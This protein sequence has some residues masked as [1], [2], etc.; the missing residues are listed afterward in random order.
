MMAT[1]ESVGVEESAMALPQSR[2]LDV[3]ADGGPA[4]FLDG[5]E[6]Q[7][8]G[9]AGDGGM[10]FT[11]VVHESGIASDDAIG[12]TQSGPF[13]QGEG[14]RNAAGDDVG[15]RVVMGDEDDRTTDEAGERRPGETMDRDR[16]DIGAS[17][18]ADG[19]DVTQQAGG[20][21][22]A[23]TAR[24]RHEDGMA[25]GHL[26][27]HR[28]AERQ[29][30]ATV[31]TDDDQFEIAR[32]RSDD[33]A[34]PCLDGADRIEAWIDGVDEAEPMEGHRGTS[35][36]LTADALERSSTGRRR[37]SPGTGTAARWVTP[38]VR[39]SR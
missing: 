18:F 21:G 39:R 33:G 31:A 26:E 8:L 28:L 14:E 19:G 5:G 35:R 29:I 37:A 16:S 22:G 25:S 4:G 10:A 36:A 9:L 17:E 38:A 3:V 20:K 11:T 6:R 30:T 1:V 15:V 13:A 23:N 32:A 27:A 12:D 24:D 7:Q 34:Q 2:D